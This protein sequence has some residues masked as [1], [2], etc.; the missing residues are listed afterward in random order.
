MYQISLYYAQTSCGLGMNRPWGRWGTNLLITSRCFCLPSNFQ[1]VAHHFLWPTVKSPA[2]AGL[3]ISGLSIKEILHAGQDIILMEPA[4]LNVWKLGDGQ[5]LHPV[6]LVGFQQCKN[7]SLKV[8][9]VAGCFKAHRH[10]LSD[11]TFI[12]DANGWQEQMTNRISPTFRRIHL[13][14]RVSERI[15]ADLGQLGSFQ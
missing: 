8:V 15:R 10:K 9:A 3:A 1:L 6:A 2:E 4:R 14:Q 12:K 5:A 13:L 7:C 11:Y